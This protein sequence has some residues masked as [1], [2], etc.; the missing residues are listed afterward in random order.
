M[1]N[2]RINPRGREDFPTLTHFA[3][4]GRKPLTAFTL[5]ASLL[6]LGR[7]LEPAALVSNRA[8]E[9]GPGRDI[10][11]AL[12]ALGVMALGAVMAR[13]TGGGSS[14]G[15]AIGGAYFQFGFFRHPSDRPP[16]GRA[17]GRRGGEA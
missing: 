16:H 5:L 11:T 4:D 9:A 3:P 10:L 13:L 7:A 15:S 17:S 8:A 12:V 14:D 1:V 2:W 6:A